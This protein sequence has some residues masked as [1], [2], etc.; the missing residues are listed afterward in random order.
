[1][2]RSAVY[3]GD[4]LHALQATRTWKPGMPFPADAAAMDDFAAACGFSLPVNSARDDSEPKP[5]DKP[6]IIKPA[7]GVPKPRPV[8]KN[9]QPACERLL[10]FWRITEKHQASADELADRRKTPEFIQNAPPASNADWEF[11]WKPTPGRT[12][13]PW[14]RLWPFLKGALGNQRRSPQIDL[15]KTVKKLAMAVPIR[16]FPQ[17]K[18]QVWQ[19]NAVLL[20]DCRPALAPFW[21]DYDWLVRRLSAVRGDLGLTIVRAQWSGDVLWD[22]KRKRHW[23]PPGTGAETAVLAL[24]DLSQFSAEQVEFQCWLRLGRLLSRRGLRPWAL[25]PCPRELWSPLLR[26]GWSLACWDHGQRLLLAP[27]VRGS[28]P[29]PPPAN[30]ENDLKAQRERQLLDLLRLASPAILV[31]RGLLRDLRLLLPH[32]SDAGTEYDAFQSSDFPGCESARQLVPRLQAAL[33]REFMDTARVSIT[34]FLSSIRLLLAHHHHSENVFGPQEWDGILD[35][36]T[37]EH[38][39]ALEQAGLLHEGI[40]DSIRL[41]WEKL[42]AG[43]HR[44]SYGEHQP[45]MLPFAGDLV[46]KLQENSLTGDLSSRRAKEIIWRLSHPD[47]ERLAPWVRPESIEFIDPGQPLKIRTLRLGDGLQFAARMETGPGV[48]G[49]IQGHRMT[50]GLSI[51]GD[52]PMTSFNTEC[53]WTTSPLLTAKELTDARRIAL[54][55]GDQRVILEKMQRPAWARRLW[56]DRHGLAV[57]F[58]V[59][60]VPFVLRWVPP[61]RF[62]MGSPEDE[63]GRWGD[64]GPRHERVIEKGFWLGETV[65]TQAQ[66][67]AVTGKNPSQFKGPGNLPVEQVAWEECRDYCEKLN[68][69]VPGPGFR[70]PWEQEWEHA[71]RAGTDTALWTGGITIREDYDAPELEDIAWYVGNSWKEPR[72]ENLYDMKSHDWRH[73]EGAEAGTHAVKGKESNLWGLYDM[74][75]NV[76]EWCEDAWDAEAY[77]KFERG[78]PLPKGDE[79]ALRVVRGGSWFFHAGGCRAAYRFWFEPDDRRSFMGFRLAAGQE[80]GAAEP[81]GSGAT[82]PKNRAERDSQPKAA[83]RAGD[84]DPA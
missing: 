18:R 45:A 10:P 59:K 39:H 71:C 81:L 25:C 54:D 69:L 53:D 12:L 38:L 8:S 72:V 57:E 42:A 29:L 75:G 66:W 48:I 6:E 40:R 33:R 62:L 26:R 17:R 61:G 47:A 56:Y 50:L 20:V 4:F 58:R 84:I 7:P 63:A 78:E 76:W 55:A 65:V 23:R 70:L 49:Q 22:V 77:A 83:R 80:P 15:P 82:L 14:K 2:H 34:L 32:A 9:G 73:P 67:L 19:S 28:A 1:M 24:G 43:L 44:Q 3:L 13:L 27:A 68:A 46:T 35:C 52:Q 60:D 37:P 21:D 16:R 79:D 30:E 5:P 11:D 74:L 41:H 31:E 36:A 64:E 51:E